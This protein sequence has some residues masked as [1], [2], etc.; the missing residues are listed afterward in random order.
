VLTRWKAPT[1]WP[2]GAI[3]AEQFGSWVTIIQGVIFVICVLTFRRGIVG[4]I[5]GLLRRGGRDAGSH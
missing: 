1:T 3:T 4:E 5:A 2:A